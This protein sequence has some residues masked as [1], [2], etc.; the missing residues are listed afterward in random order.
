MARQP[1]GPRS[2]CFQRSALL[3]WVHLQ[4]YCNIYGLLV[5][6]QHEGRW[7]R[8]FDDTSIENPMS[9]VDDE[10][11]DAAVHEACR[12]CQPKFPPE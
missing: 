12:R 6:N 10:P 3:R 4:R 8:Q 7:E 5:Y 1:C 11:P 9:D 2:R